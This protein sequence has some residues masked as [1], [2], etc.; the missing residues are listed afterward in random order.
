MCV[1]SWKHSVWREKQAC[2]ADFSILAKI[3]VSGP[4]R[5]GHYVVDFFVEFLK[6]R[7]YPSNSSETF[8][9]VVLSWKQTV[10]RKKSNV[11]GTFQFW[12]NSLYLDLTG[13]AI[14]LGWFFE[15]LKIPLPIL[16]KHS[17]CCSFMKSQTVWR[18]NSMFWGPFNFDQIRCIWTLPAWPFF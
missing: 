6:C 4:H 2:L 3:A 12:S 9:I 13:V 11:L 7:K 17:K 18:K 10:W 1:L 16:L 14:F 15:M 8:K 5:G